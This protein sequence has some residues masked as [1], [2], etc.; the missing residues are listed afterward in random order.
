MAED[1]KALDKEYIV[2]VYN[3]IGAVLDYGKGAILYD[4]DGKNISISV[5]ALPSIFL[6]SVM[7]NGRRLWKHRSIN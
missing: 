3:R 5:P 1:Y 7:M 2:N 6:A 4:V